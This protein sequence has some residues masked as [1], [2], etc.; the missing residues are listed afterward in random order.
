MSSKAPIVILVE[1]ELDSTV[2]DN[3][4]VCKFIVAYTVP[5]RAYSEKHPSAL[6]R[7]I[8]SRTFMKAK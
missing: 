4:M 8:V 2:C 3:W 6:K 5:R 1:E 7:Q